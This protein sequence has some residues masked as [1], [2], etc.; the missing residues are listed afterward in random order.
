MPGFN[1]R[2]P[3]NQGPM[4]GRGMGV[5]TGN[6][7]AGITE[8]S[9][10]LEFGMRRGMGRQA[11]FGRGRRVSPWNMPPARPTD[12]PARP[13]DT[14]DDLEQRAQAL[15]SELKAVKDALNTLS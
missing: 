14:K 2:G 5:C 15:E 9:V 13:I 1:Q 4:T 3:M 8:N 7:T 12:T 10:P 11:G 6:R